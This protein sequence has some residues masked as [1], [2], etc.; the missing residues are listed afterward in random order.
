ML[1]VSFNSVY[2]G[3]V[4]HGGT[5]SEGTFLIED[6]YERLTVVVVVDSSPRTDGCFSIGGIRDGQARREV[7]FRLGPECRL[8]V[9]VPGRSELQIR[10]IDLPLLRGSFA[11]QEPG[12][13]ID[14]WGYLLAFG[15]V[16]SLQDCVAHPKCKGEVGNDAPG[17]LHEPF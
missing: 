4:C 1:G 8:V 15:L 16:R 11:L 14:G 3:G 17:V 5:N 6:I 12:V 13:G 9:I 10:L 7:V 2:S